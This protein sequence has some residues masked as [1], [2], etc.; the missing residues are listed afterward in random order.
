MVDGKYLKAA[1]L[2][3]VPLSFPV[4]CHLID[5][6]RME[7]TAVKPVQSIE[8]HEIEEE[9]PIQVGIRVLT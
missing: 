2:T 1:S 8:L 5:F 6:F 3:N 4:C 7:D 9:R